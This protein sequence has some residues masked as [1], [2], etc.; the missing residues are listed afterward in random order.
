MPDFPASWLPSL[1][2]PLARAVL[3]PM[4]RYSMNSRLPWALQRKLLD[5]GAVLQAVPAGTRV[6]RMRLAGRPAER[7]SAGTAA[8]PGAVLYLHGGGYTIG[9]P[10]THRSLAGWLARE[11]GCP[12]Y[13]PDYRLAPEHPYPAALDD[14]EAAFLE[15]VSTGLLPR[16][17]AVA[18]DS[19]GGGLALALALRLRDRHG[20]VPAAL[21]LIAP[22]ADPNELAE[23]DRDLVINAAWSR[24]CAAAYLGGA[25]PLDVGYAPLLGDLR[26]LPTT[27]IQ[28]D[29][30]ELL[31]AQCVRLAAALR[32]AEVPVHFSV[33]DGL[34]HVAQAQASLVRPAG[35]AAREL[36]RFLGESLQPAQTG[37]IG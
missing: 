10:A 25:D 35:A 3:H 15:L 31:H 6:H 12:I 9:S 13:V 27:Y 24:S 7:V 19:A 2:L 37:S 33:T 23:R 29:S 32:T 18:G 21:G 11:T 5:S 30:G 26:G 36:G 1:P 20:I 8:G 28:A 22:W 4:F 14:A 34:W 17:I 16:E